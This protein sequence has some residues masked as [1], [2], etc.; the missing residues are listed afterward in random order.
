MR[1]KRICTRT[2]CFTKVL[3]LNTFHKKVLILVLKILKVLVL[4]LNTFICTKTQP[5]LTCHFKYD[6]L[7]QKLFNK[8]Q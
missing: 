4:V 7:K 6:Y 8:Q 5:W 2:K 3:V 1:E